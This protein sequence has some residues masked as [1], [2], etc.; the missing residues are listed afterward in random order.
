MNNYQ[1]T[2]GIEIHAQLNTKRKIFSPSLNNSNSKPNT[3][4]HPIDLAFPGALPRFNEEVLSKSL[5]ICKALNME[6]TKE[7]HWDRKNYFYHDNPKGYQITQKDTPIGRNGQIKLD[8]GTIIGIDFMHMEEDTAKSFHT[9]DAI[10]LDFNRSGVPLVEIVSKPEIHSANQAKEYIEKLREILLFL[11]VS[12]GKMEEGSLRVDVNV[13][14]RPFGQEHLNE[15]V[16][17]K[18]LNS[19]SNVI[20]SIEIE[21][22]DQIKKYNTS[23]L[24][25]SST[26]K[27][28][29]DTKQLEIMRTKNGIIDYRYFAEP[30]LPKIKLTDQY[31]NEIIESIP[32][33][34][35]EIKEQLQEIGVSNKDIN[36]LFSD[37]QMLEFYL[38]LT[39]ENINLKNAL[40]YLLVNVNEY[41]N[42]NKLQM[43]DVKLTVDNIIDLEFNLQNGKISSAHVKKIIPIICEKD[44][45]VNQVIEDLNIAQITDI[46]QINDL[47]MQVIKNN[48]QSIVDYHNGKD[49]AFGFLI[50]QIMKLSKGQANPKL[51]SDCLV[52]KLKESIDENIE[53]N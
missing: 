30:D 31:I 51:V 32:K 27:Y 35:N 53:K 42:K 34:P 29:E 24:V 40:N 15:K 6:I 22:K 14:V 3:N 50:G 45:N 8:D 46:N 19:F 17:I 44:I 41:L 33:L 21:V 2:I 47:V 16:E 28:V 9:K 36:I 38:Q 12:D 1:T 43:K 25:E 48:N 5:L 10:L 37:L 7:M 11:N 23:Q 26:K 13:S 18:N 4:I 49:R 52:L 20:Q 39:K